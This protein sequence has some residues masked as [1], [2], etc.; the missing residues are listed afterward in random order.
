MSPRPA[1]A[2][3]G[4]GIAGLAGALALLDAGA[5]VVLVEAEGRLGGKILTEDFAGMAVEAGPDAFLARVPHAV[6]LC[7]RLDLSHEL[8]SPTTAR[9]ALWSRGRLRMLP[10]GLVLGVPTRWGPLAR[11]GILSPLGVARAAMD[12]VLPATAG[13]PERSVGDLVRARL[14]RQVAERLVDPL[15]GGINAGRADGLSAAAVAPVLDA[16][17]R[18][19]RSLVQGLQTPPSVAPTAAPAA[20]PMFLTHPGGLGRIVDALADRLL[21]GGAELR[22]AAPVSVMS[23]I[24]GGWSLATAQGALR[25]DGVLLAVPGFVAAQLLYPHLPDAA[26]L[27]GGINYA[28]V[29][30]VTLAYPEGAVSRP[31]EGTGFLV[32]AGEGRITSACTFTS[33][34]WPQVSWRDH[35]IFRASVGRWGDSRHQV[36]GNAELVSVVHSELTQALGLRSRPVQW[37]VSRWPRSFPQ[38][39]LGH[40]GR[41][42]RVEAEVAG[43]GTVALAGAAYRGLGI[44]ACIAGAQRAAGTLM[45]ALAGNGG[46]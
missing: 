37:R 8:V 41:V 17:A 40:L 23:R 43:L 10:A 31:L 20:A 46:E 11:S 24:A 35:V 4:G 12:L 38:Y 22:T 2:V 36:L 14:G 34:K 13:A 7:R 6:D 16:A 27:L 26:R 21:A 1:V 30:L 19:S 25:A 44:P 32:P 29:G 28:S 33:R 18:R 3:V 42:A 5:G 39:E 45:A 9:A 15:V